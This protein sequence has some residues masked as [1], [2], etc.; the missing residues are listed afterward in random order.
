MGVLQPHAPRTLRPRRCCDRPL[1]FTKATLLA[2]RDLTLVA[3]NL[4]SEPRY[5]RELMTPGTTDR[6][7][8][9]IG[10]AGAGEVE[11]G[12]PEEGGGAGV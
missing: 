1:A 5:C 4:T 11:T 10:L 3:S 12:V 6:T 8:T 9:N 7:E 2:L